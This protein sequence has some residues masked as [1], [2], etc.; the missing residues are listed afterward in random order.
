MTHGQV[1]HQS[2]CN[3]YYTGGKVYLVME[4]R[5]K[6]EATVWPVREYAPVLMRA[7][8]DKDLT[9]FESWTFASELP[10]YQA[11][12][13]ADFD[14]FGVPFY[15]TDPIHGADASPGRN[16]AGVPFSRAF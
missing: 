7:E 16:C 13:E 3:V 9:R 2:A 12:D 11:A 10:F 4:R 8:V 5:M 6:H 1:W 15:K 14:Y